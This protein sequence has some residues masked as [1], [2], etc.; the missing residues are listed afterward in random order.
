[1][2]IFTENIDPSTLSKLYDINKSGLY[3]H[4]RVMPDV[5]EGSSIVGFTGYFKDSLSPD[6]IGPD[7]GC[8]MLCL[9]LGKIEID[10]EKLD[11]V[12]HRYVP[13]GKAVNG[14][15]DKYYRDVNIRL[16]DLNCSGNLTRIPELERAIG[17]LGGGNLFIA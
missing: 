3:E 1:M 4:I 14:I 12:I 2:K 10:P 11:R 9:N 13:D 17:S 15:N 8:G 16:D 7:I 5:H 6:V